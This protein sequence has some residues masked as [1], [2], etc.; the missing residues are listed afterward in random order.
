MQ[1]YQCIFNSLSKSAHAIVALQKAEYTLGDGNNA[2]VSGT[3]LL[4]VV[5]RKPHVDPNA[6]R[7]SHILTQLGHIDK[8]VADLK[9]NNVKVNEKVK[10]LVEELAA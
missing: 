6:T 5:I 1:M 7:T 8:I 9:S 3:C 4:K 10:A 2:I